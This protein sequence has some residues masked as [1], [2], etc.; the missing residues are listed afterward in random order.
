MPSRMTERDVADRRATI[1]VAAR[2]CFLDVGYGKTAFDDDAVRAGVSRTLLY[3]RSRDKN[4]IYQAVFADWLLARRPAVGQAA[5]GSESGHDRL[6]ATCDLLVVEPWAE[7]VDAA[8]GHAF[9]ET[10]ARID[11]ENEALFRAVAHEAGTHIPGD[12]NSAGVFLLA[13]DGLLA[14]GPASPVLQARVRLLAARFAP[15][16]PH[17]GA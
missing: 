12:Q 15:G 17:D 8:M 5:A 9:L 2:W 4:A 13:L 6:L 14:D 7:M 10:C 3:T 1:L 11:P 16:L